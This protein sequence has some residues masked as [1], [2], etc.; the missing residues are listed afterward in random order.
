MSEP[1]KIESSY[2]RISQKPGAPSVIRVYGHPRDRDTNARS[3]YFSNNFCQSNHIPFQQPENYCKLRNF[4][5]QPKTLTFVDA[6]AEG[7]TIVNVQ[8]R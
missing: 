5:V 6:D 1:V 3:S 8:K 4:K 7:R 2:H